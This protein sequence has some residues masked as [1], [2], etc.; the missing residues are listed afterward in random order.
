MN[1]IACFSASASLRLRCCSTVSPTVGRLAFRSGRG[2]ERPGYS[3][4]VQ[5]A[6][7]V[8]YP[9][10]GL[11]DAFTPEVVEA[12]EIAFGKGGLIIDYLT[13]S[14]SWVR[15]VFDRMDSFRVA[16]GE[17]P[18]YPRSETA[19]SWFPISVVRPSDW[20]TE[21]HSYE[22]RYYGQS[23]QFGGDVDEMLREFEHYLFEFHD[24]FVEVIAGGIHFEAHGDQPSGTEAAERPGWKWLPDSAHEERWQLSGIDCRLRMSQR[25]HADVI[26][27]STLCDQVL[28]DLA[29]DLDGRLQ[30]THRLCVRTR[31]GRT[32]SRWRGSFGN[33]EKPFEG[34]PDIDDIR[35]LIEQYVAEVQDRR[36]TMRN[37]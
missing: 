27:S 30:N 25:S 35:P 10:R 31:E 23:Y 33:A 21:R 12:P 6:P 19:E 24:E 9:I 16:R 20:L 4:K 32:V 26:A 22:S 15:T 7:S 18:P 37:P 17:Y 14:D 34:I 3:R 5:Q 1:S 28:F 2:V 13:Q 11:G 29:L 8:T 36:L